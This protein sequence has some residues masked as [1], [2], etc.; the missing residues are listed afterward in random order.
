MRK[1]RFAK[2]L[3]G[4]EKSAVYRVL[5]ELETEIAELAEKVESLGD[6]LKE[7]T[8]QREEL[9]LTIAAMRRQHIQMFAQ[10]DGNV[11]PVTV[12]I[13]PTRTLG[14]ITG[15][16]DS[17][18]GCPHLIPK[19]RVFRDGFYRVDGSAVDKDRLIT[20]LH[21]LSDVRD[22]IVEGETLHVLPRGESA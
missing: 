20:W 1:Y 14:D 22:T 16:I 15:L 12:M 5:D 9:S 4:F 13:G 17:M 2:Q 3:F 10:K 18:E 6:Q 19:F 8:A 7:S 21:S 11:E